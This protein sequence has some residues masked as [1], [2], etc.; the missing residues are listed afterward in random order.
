MGLGPDVQKGEVKTN[1]VV[2]VVGVLLVMVVA[3]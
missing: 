3:M 2:I 1:A